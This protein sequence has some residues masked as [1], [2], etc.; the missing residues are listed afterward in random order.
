MRHHQGKTFIA[1]EQPFKSEVAKYFPNFQGYTLADSWSYLDTTKVLRGKVSIVSF[2]SESWAEEQ[3]RSFVGK[4]ENA[5]LARLLEELKGEKG[6][7]K[8][9]INYED[10]W[11]KKILIYMFLWYARRK[12]DRLDGKDMR[13]R[14]FIV[15][16]GVDREF[17]ENG[18]GVTNLRVGYVY[19]VDQNCKIRWVGNGDASEAEKAS[20]VRVARRLVGERQSRS[21]KRKPPLKT[22]LVEEKENGPKPLATMMM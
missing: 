13:A 18:L 11:F 5:K 14:S 12:S 22:T 17:F 16:R 20:L 1:P 2:V 10:D 21:E 15:T 6:L 9:L 4:K 19:L 7:H 3:A 8:V